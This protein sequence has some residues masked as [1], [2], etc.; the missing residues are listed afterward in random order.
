MTKIVR[1]TVERDEFADCPSEYDGWKL[2]SFNR[3]HINYR[4]LDTL[5]EH[6]DADGTV[7]PR[8]IGLSRMLNVGTAFIVSCYEHSGSVWGLRGEV[9]QCQ[10]DTAQLAGILI[11]E[12]KVDN[13][14]PKPY[15][16][17]DAVKRAVLRY[18]DR[19]EDARQF[20]KLY[21]QWVNGENYNVVVEDEDGE[22]QSTGGYTGS[23]NLKAELKA[24][25]PEVFEA[26][27]KTIKSEIEIDG[28]MKEVLT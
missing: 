8:N 24:E 21:T 28:E 4:D 27:G 1:L 12:D 13:L 10:W 6:V 17:A 23:D 9:F 19:E 15:K 18:Q 25:F 3:R 16:D 11:W 5:F 2:Y 26:D 7:F 14:C 22:T 20:L